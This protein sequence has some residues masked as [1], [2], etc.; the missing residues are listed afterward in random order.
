MKLKNS[1]DYR[2]Y[3]NDKLS[4]ANTNREDHKVIA[5]GANFRHLSVIDQKLIERLR[6][7]FLTFFLFF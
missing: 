1:S 4:I 5:L 3:D 7:D 2:H 6:Y